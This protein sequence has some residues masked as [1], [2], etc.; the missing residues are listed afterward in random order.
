M[1]LIT[2]FIK[3]LKKSFSGKQYL[4]VLN[5][6]DMCGKDSFMYRCLKCEMDEV[7]RGF[8]KKY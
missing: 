1:S 2:N 8:N 3:G 6:C 7:Y 5:T 4:R